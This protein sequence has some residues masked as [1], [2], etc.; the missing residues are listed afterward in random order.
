M[1]YKPKS[2]GIG[3]LIIAV[4]FWNGFVLGFDGLIVWKLIEQQNAKQSYIAADAI[5][6]GSYVSITHSGGGRGSG[7]S[8]V[9]YKPA[10]RYEYKVDGQQYEGDRYSFVVWGRG[11]PD[12]AQALTDRFSFGDQ[13]T[14]YHDPDNPSESVMDRSFGEFPT[15]VGVILLPFHCLGMI[16]VYFFRHTWRY[17]DLDGDARWIEP[18]I[19]SR[20]GS[21]T[22]LRDHAYPLWFVFLSTLG[23]A[24]FVMSFVLMFVDGGFNSSASVVVTTLISCVVLAVLNTIRKAKKMDD[25]SSRLIIDFKA[26]TL[27]RGDQT[28]DMSRIRSLAVDSKTTS[29]NKREGWNTHTARARLEDGRWFDLLIARGHKDHARVFKRCM[30]HELRLTASSKPRSS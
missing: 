8:T 24:G 21:R 27:S 1:A 17:K 11:T 20:S 30:K 6:T 13:I 15:F 26:K 3:C 25:P 19:D 12:Y 16:G 9:D 5:V 4:I 28:L 23:V 18:Y 29:T 2:M 14:I 10:F 22:V 7:T